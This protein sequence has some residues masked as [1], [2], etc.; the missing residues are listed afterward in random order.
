[1]DVIKPFAK[2]EKGLKTV[3][4]AVMTFSQNIA[5][6]FSM[7]KYA[8]LIMKRGKREKTEGIELWN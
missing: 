6:E 4:Q 7:G 8:I 3:I 2:N 5:M 1:M